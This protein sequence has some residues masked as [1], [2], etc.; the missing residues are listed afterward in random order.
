MTLYRD[1]RL[2]GQV[3]DVLRPEDSPLMLVH[4]N[5][6][7]C[8]VFLC[9][10]SPDTGL[11]TPCGTAFLLTSHH[12]DLQQEATGYL[13]TAKHVI[14]K[15]DQLVTEGK[16]LDFLWV[17]GNNGHGLVAEVKIPRS[18]WKFH[19]SD[20]TVDV[21]AVAWGPEHA[22][23]L[24]IRSCQHGNC[25][26]STIIG[27]YGIGPGDPVF[28]PGLYGKHSGKRAI[29]AIVRCGTVAMMPTEPVRGGDIHGHEIY[30]NGHLIELRSISGLSGSPVFVHATGLRRLRG[31]PGMPEVGTLSHAAPTYLFGLIHGHWDE[32]SES[33]EKINTGISI[34]VPVDKII[35]VIYQEAFV[36][37]RRKKASKRE[38]EGAAT[39]DSVD[40]EGTPQTPKSKQDANQRAKSAID[41]IARRTEGR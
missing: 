29:D 6:K 22:N 15:V 25:A 32:K 39:V 20:A 38:R 36:D 23:G 40:D 8:A 28:V 27:K 4:E 13:V 24:L 16:A 10:E 3:E 37:E 9:R 26:T 35:E 30:M 12:N 31:I 5:V 17:R 7:E 2:G 18:A 33:R 14:D 19:P 34:V 1:C 21:A 41:E 11:K